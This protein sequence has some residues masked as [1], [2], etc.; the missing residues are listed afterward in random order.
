MAIQARNVAC[1]PLSGVD[2]E[3]VFDVTPHALATAEHF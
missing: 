1:S 2:K 3:E